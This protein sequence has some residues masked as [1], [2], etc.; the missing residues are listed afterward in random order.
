MIILSLNETTSRGSF[1]H[2]ETK[3]VQNGCGCGE[4]TRAQKNQNWGYYEAKCL[5][6]IWADKKNT[7]AIISDG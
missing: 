1:N 6:E 3:Y 2:N 7:T 5:V 4:G